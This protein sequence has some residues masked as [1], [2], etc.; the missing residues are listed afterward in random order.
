MNRTTKADIIRRA[1]QVIVLALVVVITLML[2]KNIFYTM[3]AGFVTLIIVGS[4]E[5]WVAYLRWVTPTL[6][7]D[8]GC[9]R[10]FRHIDKI[11]VTSPH[12]NDYDY[13]VYATGGSDFTWFP[14][15]GGFLENPFVIVPKEFIIST[16]GGSAGEI[17]TGNIHE[18]EYD[19]LPPFLQQALE[20][21]PCGHFNVTTSRIKK[22][23]VS[24]LN[25]SNTSDNINYSQQRDEW[26]KAYSKQKELVDKL[27]DEVRNIKSLERTIDDTEKQKYVIVPQNDVKR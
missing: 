12:Q 19:Q 23:D 20:R 11:T 10:S 27:I 6:L 22:I 15:R 5:T 8:D 7:T 13:V 1:P 21:H 3:I 9:R 4:E 24:F 18:V 2:W 25:L 26:I 16:D 14:T 17:A